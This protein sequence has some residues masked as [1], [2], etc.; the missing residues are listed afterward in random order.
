M[1]VPA[2]YV[3]EMWPKAYVRKRNGRQQLML[4]AVLLRPAG[5]QKIMPCCAA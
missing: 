4:F 1:A 5:I 3:A 2:A